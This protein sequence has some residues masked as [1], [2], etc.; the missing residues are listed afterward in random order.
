MLGE[1]PGHH[2]AQSCRRRNHP[3]AV[4]RTGATDRSIFIELDEGDVI[5]ACSR[6]AASWCAR[7]LCLASSSRGQHRSARTSSGQLM[8]TMQLERDT[9][10]LKQIHRG[11]VT[12][13]RVAWI[14]HTGAL[15]IDTELK[16]KAAFEATPI[17]VDGR[18][19][20]TTPFNQVLALNPSTGEKLWEFDG[21]SI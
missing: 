12:K 17:M 4:P 1:E 14:I 18:L 15:D 5:H 11:N 2:K 10:P 13:L 8:V 20:L 9:R 19:Y 16:K 3:D 6:P 21:I 7:Y